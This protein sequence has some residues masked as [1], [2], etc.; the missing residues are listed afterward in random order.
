MPLHERR[1]RYWVCKQPVRTCRCNT[2]A[3]YEPPTSTIQVSSSSCQKRK[4]S[5]PSARPHPVSVQTTAR[6]VETLVLTFEALRRLLKH[7]ESETQKEKSTTTS[8]ASQPAH[9]ERSTTVSAQ[10]GSSGK[11]GGS[12][13][14]LDE[15]DPGVDA[16]IAAYK[17]TLLRWSKR[18]AELT[19]PGEVGGRRA[20]KI[21]EEGRDSEHEGDTARLARTAQNSKLIQTQRGP[22]GH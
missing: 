2:N 3:D 1:R 16:V 5:M 22:P 21:S 4:L 8:A 9:L 15:R 12:C 14:S 17:S 20:H 18:H 7:A 13:A 10:S 6:F 19:N 11:L